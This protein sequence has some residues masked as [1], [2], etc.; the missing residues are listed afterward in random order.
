MET[1][2]KQT[3]ISEWTTLS[4]TCKIRIEVSDGTTH[5]DVYEQWKGLM[6]AVGYCMKDYD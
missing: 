6:E 3:A 1:E 4:G 5:M 2:T